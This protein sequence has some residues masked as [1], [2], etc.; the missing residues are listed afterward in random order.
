[1]GTIFLVG[2]LGAIVS[3]ITGTLWYMDSTPM[4]K[5][6]MEYLGFDKLSN[7]EKEKLIAKAKPDMWKSYSAQMLL[8]FFTSFFI[9]FVTSYTVQNGGPAN[10]VY[11]YVPMIWLAFT[12]P[13]IGQNI[14]WGKSEGSL[15]WKRFFSDSFYN[16][17][18]FFIIAFV[19][20]LII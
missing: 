10:A 19:A 3:A 12:V 4:G 16:L 13:M 20:T 2:I 8:S 15:A 18:T 9:G 11:S 1:M 6:H 17:I 14:L 7:E 5:W